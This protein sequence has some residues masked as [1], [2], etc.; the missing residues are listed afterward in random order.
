MTRSTE[1]SGK[2][3]MTRAAWPTKTRSTNWSIVFGFCG[4]GRIFTLRIGGTPH[5]VYAENSSAPIASRVFSTFM[6]SLAR[7]E[8]SD[9]RLLIIPRMLTGAVPATT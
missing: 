4:P 9:F 6:R 7:T 2:S 8:R 5:V 3:A 1:L